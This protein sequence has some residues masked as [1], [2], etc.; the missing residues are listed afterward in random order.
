VVHHAVLYA[1]N[2]AAAEAQAEGLDQAAG[3]PGY[4]CFGG[5]GVPAVPVMAWAPGMP[6]TSYPDGTGLHLSAGRKLVLQVHYNLTFGALPDR[7][8]IDISLAPSV[9]KP[10][11]MYATLDFN[12]KLAPGQ[13]EVVDDS[14][15]MNNSPVPLT[16]YGIFPHM[17]TL[18]RTLSLEADLSGKTTCIGDVPDWNF[19]WQQFYM[20]SAPITLDPGATL[21]LKC[22]YDTRGQVD[23]VTWGEG[24]KDEMCVAMLYVT[25]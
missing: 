14:A 2:D 3:G 6:A 5:V 7:T 9:A 25:K 10:A 16:V 22:T 24:T 18:G 13:K 15:S 4:Q 19:H 11:S 21:R 17:H 23:T 12:L 20:Y 1:P 8:K